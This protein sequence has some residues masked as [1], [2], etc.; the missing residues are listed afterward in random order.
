M[1]PKVLDA[2]AVMAFFENEPG[3]DHVRELISTAEASHTPL[4]M[5][6]VNLG[7]VWYSIARKYTAR[8]ADRCIQEVQ[9]MPIEVVPADW[10]LTHLAAQFKA[11]GKL[12]YGDCFAA[13]LARLKDA[14]LVTG[15]K[16]FMSIG[17]QISIKWI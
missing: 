10:A 13:A 11:D 2:F 5:S 12:S 9:A 7:E 16:E 3:A 1:T 17:K 14:E 6:V 4:L 8:Q 15:D